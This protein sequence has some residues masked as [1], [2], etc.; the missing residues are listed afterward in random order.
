MKQL[1]Y[2]NCPDED[3]THLVDCLILLVI[4]AYT[5]YLWSRPAVIYIY[6]EFLRSSWSFGFSRSFTSNLKNLVFSLDSH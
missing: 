6:A 5:V 2:Q 1:S 3:N 4:S